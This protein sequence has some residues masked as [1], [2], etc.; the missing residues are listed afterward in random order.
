[1]FTFGCCCT[2]GNLTDEQFFLKVSSE[3]KNPISESE[4]AELEWAFCGLKTS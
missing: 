2:K 1:M 3:D 4:G